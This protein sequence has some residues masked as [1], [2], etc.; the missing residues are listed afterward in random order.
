[1]TVGLNSDRRRLPGPCPGNQ[2][3]AIVGGTGALFGVR[4]QKG[5]AHNRLSSSTPKRTAS[6]T[7]DPAK[8]RQNG[9]GHVASVL[10]VIPVSRPDIVI[11]ANGPAVTPPE[12][13][14]RR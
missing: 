2:N 1:M 8:R 9:G 3:Y 4:G 6:I 5:G 12:V 10:Y 13:P 14:D 7:E 11:T